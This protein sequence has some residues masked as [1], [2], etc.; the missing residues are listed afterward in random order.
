[1]GTESTITVIM[2]RKPW[3]LRIISGHFDFDNY[4]EAEI[5][6]RWPKAGSQVVRLLR[7]YKWIGRR[8]TGNS[9]HALNGLLVWVVIGGPFWLPL[10]WFW[11]LPV[12]FYSMR[13]I[14]ELIRGTPD[15]VDNLADF[16]WVY[17]LGLAL[18][19]PPDWWAVFVL[20]CVY[21]IGIQV[22]YYTKPAPAWMPRDRWLLWGGG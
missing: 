17:A 6:A 2:N 15:P 12:A 11:V 22:L 4:S 9:T 20:W 1:M 18:W 3:Y 7:M 19:L 5:L 10:A 14:P 13:E 21:T 8:V 16:A